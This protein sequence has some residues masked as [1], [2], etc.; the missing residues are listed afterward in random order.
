M[1]RSSQLKP[2]RERLRH[3]RTLALLATPAVVGAM[4]VAVPALAGTS[5]LG[6][7][8]A[9]EA[10]STHC[11]TAIVHHRRVRECLVAGARG[12]RGFTGAPGPRGLKGSTGA[13]GSKGSTGAKGATGAT[14]SAGA[15][16]TVGPQGPAGTA[17][18]YG[19][20]L[21]SATVVPAQSSNITGISNPK[22]G[23]YCVV[24]AS[25]INPAADTAA[26]SAEVSYSAE[27]PGL[28]ALNAQRPNCAGGGFEVDTYSPST[29]VLSGGYAFTIVIP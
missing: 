15:A 6:S 9:H 12:P 1:P 18:A 17:R 23:V 27:G 25:P 29:S 26:V 3:P 28:V 16:G 13:K 5:L 11:V 19:V 8:T 21:P 7:G 4:T 14:G 2:R 22:V 20:V 24:A 10:S